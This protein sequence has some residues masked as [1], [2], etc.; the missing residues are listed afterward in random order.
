MID[1]GSIGG[2]SNPPG[3]SKFQYMVS[4]AQSVEREFVEL[5]EAGS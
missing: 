3:D 2:G 1:Y 5:E 4:V